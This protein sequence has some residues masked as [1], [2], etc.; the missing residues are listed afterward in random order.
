MWQGLLSVLLTAVFPAP[1]HYQ[2]WK[3]IFSSE[4]IYY[5][6][7]EE[8]KQTA[9]GDYFFTDYFP[10]LPHSIATLVQRAWVPGGRCVKE[11]DK[12]RQWWC[13]GGKPQGLKVQ[14]GWL[15]WDVLLV[16]RE[17]WPELHVNA[18]M[19]MLEES[20]VARAVTA[21]DESG[22]VCLTGAG[23][24]FK[25]RFSAGFGLEPSE[26][27]LPAT[28]G[29]REEEGRAEE[30]W[31]I[32]ADCSKRTGHFSLPL[33][34]EQGGQRAQRAEENLI[35]HPGASMMVS[36]LCPF[37]VFLEGILALVLWKWRLWNW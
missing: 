33:K 23:R 35:R 17:G 21:H 22:G 29:A 36:M 6:C 14:M 27:E 11:A 1:K 20:R 13:S 15:R 26:D 34:E 9:L 31:R 18:D 30:S 25:Q 2:R 5:C 3:K 19:Q 16:R 37:I 10:Y 24:L 4:S 8:V 32:R 12:E 7:L 28:N